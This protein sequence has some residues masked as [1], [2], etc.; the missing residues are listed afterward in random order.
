[1]VEIPIQIMELFIIIHQED[2]PVE[3][4]IEK[5]AVK[6]L[7]GTVLSVEV[8]LIIE[9]ITY[10]FQE[11]YPTNRAYHR[12]AILTL[13]NVIYF[14]AIA[15]TFINWFGSSGCMFVPICQFYAEWTG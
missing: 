14:I 13:L 11:Y 6:Y 2:S 8:L 4:I 5:L 15:I 9:T 7:L 12:E 10:A 1:M 3:T